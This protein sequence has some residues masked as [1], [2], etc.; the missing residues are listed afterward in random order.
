VQITY[1]RHAR[2]HIPEGLGITSCFVFWAGS[3]SRVVS[4]AAQADAGCWAESQDGVVVAETELGQRCIFDATFGE[5]CSRDH[6]S[7][8][9]DGFDGSPRHFVIM[10]PRE[11][12]ASG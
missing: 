6:D 11:F 8:D 3:A 4:R 7:N 2:L 1:L 9:Q 5:G 10:T 12:T